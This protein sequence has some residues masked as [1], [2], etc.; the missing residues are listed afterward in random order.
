M[1]EKILCYSCN[2]TKNKLN[3]KRSDLLPINL[4]MC[5]TCIDEKMEPRWVV[6]IAG[7]QNG[8][9]H[10][11]DFIQKKRYIGTEIAASELLV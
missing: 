6:V 8:H 11:K 9:E 7:R 1:S 4:F 10:V 5:Q 3:L 2:K